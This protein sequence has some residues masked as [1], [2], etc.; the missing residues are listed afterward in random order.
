MLKERVNRSFDRY[1]RFAKKDLTD[2]WRV[3]AGTQQLLQAMLPD[4]PS[5]K[6]EYQD[7]K[8]KELI[9]ENTFDDADC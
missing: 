4:G 5:I 8:P 1:A 9:C 7:I 6:P 3:R 2:D